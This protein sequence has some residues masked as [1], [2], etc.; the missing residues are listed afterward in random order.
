[1]ANSDTGVKANSRP[2]ARIGW[3]DVAKG[4]AI[5]LVIV[6]HTL[7]SGGAPWRTVFSFHMPLFFI[8]AG[9][10]FRARKWGELVPSSAR[11]LLFP[12]FLMF[13]LLAVRS[14]AG[15]FLE[16]RRLL[17]SLAYALAYQPKQLAWTVDI[18]YV[19]AIWFLLCMFMSRMYLNAALKFFG[20]HPMH[21][22]VRLAAMGALA[23]CGVLAGRR[24]LVPFTFDIAL[25]GAFFMYLGW[26]FRELGQAAS[27]RGW[28]PTVLAAL[29]WALTFAWSGLEMGARDYTCFPL[30]VVCACAGSFVCVNAAMFLDSA[31]Q[32]G[33]GLIVPVSRY[34]A[35]MGRES[36]AVFCVHCFESGVIAWRKLPFLMG[37]PGEGLVAGIVRVAFASLVMLLTGIL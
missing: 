33:A 2:C 16:P 10:T 12:Y 29:L 28:K 15:L 30:A 22:A 21:E 19:G 5:L 27:L 23:Y 1:M 24:I 18:P 6:G 3:V 36:M 35:F 7:S 20:R 31:A 25:V 9:Y 26:E 37:V 4:I 32:E 8:L 34:L 13:L 11:R 14:D 17:E